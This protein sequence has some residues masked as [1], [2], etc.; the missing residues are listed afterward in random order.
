M[1]ALPS[2]ND[3]RTDSFSHK[4]ARTKYFVSGD[5]DGTSSTKRR[6][7]A[8]TSQQKVQDF[9]PQGGKF[10]THADV[11]VRTSS[12]EENGMGVSDVSDSDTSSSSE[13]RTT[14][15]DNGLLTSSTKQTD[16]MQTGSIVNWNAGAKSKIRTTLG[17]NGGSGPKPPLSEDRTSPSHLKEQDHQTPIA[18]ELEHDQ[19]LEIEPASSNSSSTHH[20]LHLPPDGSEAPNIAASKEL[21][22]ADDLELTANIVSASEN[23]SKCSSLPQLMSPASDT[24]GV[25]AAIREG[26]KPETGLQNSRIATGHPGLRSSWLPLDVYKTIYQFVRKLPSEQERCERTNRQMLYIC[27]QSHTE[28]EASRALP[29]ERRECSS[30]ELRAYLFSFDLDLP[31]Q[32]NVLEQEKLMAAKYNGGEIYQGQEN[33]TEAIFL[34]HL[35]EQKSVDPRRREVIHETETAF[36]KHIV[37]GY[38][39]DHLMCMLL[40]PDERYE[41]GIGSLQHNHPYHT[42]QEY[43]EHM[44]GRCNRLFTDLEDPSNTKM[45]TSQR[46]TKVD[47]DKIMYEYGHPLAPQNRTDEDSDDAILSDTKNNKRDEDI[48]PNNHSSKCSSSPHPGC[49][50]EPDLGGKIHEVEVAYWYDRISREEYNERR[51]KLYT[52]EEAKEYGIEWP[53]RRVFSP[54]G[55]RE[56]EFECPG[57]VLYGGEK[58][59]DL[60]LEFGCDNRDAEGEAAARERFE[61]RIEARFPDIEARQEEYK[62]WEKIKEVEVEFCH[63]RISRDE[64]NERR[65]A[66]YSKGEL[67][68]REIEWPSEH[69]Q[70]PAGRRD[71]IFGTFVRDEPSYKARMEFHWPFPLDYTDT[72]DE[73]QLCELCTP[74]I[75][76]QRI[77]NAKNEE[78]MATRRAIETAE[79]KVKQEKRNAERAAKALEKK[80]LVVE[81][82]KKK[83]KRKKSKVQDVP[84]SAK[85]TKDAMSDEKGCKGPSTR[86]FQALSMLDLAE[87]GERDAESAELARKSIDLPKGRTE[88]GRQ[89][90]PPGDDSEGSKDEGE[91]SEVSELDADSANPGRPPVHK[92]STTLKSEMDPSQPTTVSDLPIYEMQLQSRYFPVVQTGL[93]NKGNNNR[94]ARCLV[95]VGEGHTG[96]NCLELT[97]R[98][99]LGGSS[100]C[101]D[102]MNRF[103]LT[104]HKIERKAEFSIKGRATHRIREDSESE[105]FFRPPVA[106]AA[107]GRRGG[108]DRRSPDRPIRVRMPENYRAR[109]PRQSGPPSESYYYPQRGERERKRSLSPL[110]RHPRENWRDSRRDNYQGRGEG[111][112][113]GDSWQPPLPREPPPTGGG[114]GG[115]REKGQGRGYGDVYRPMPSAANNARRQFRR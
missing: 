29:R 71:D 108:S 24:E 20:E 15:S 67:E 113:R 45:A 111:K 44:L 86:N 47:Y 6:K 28:S 32:L 9:V 98:S 81:K 19:G 109:S 115:G 37:E 16:S 112:G 26:R 30:E 107:R 35:D 49:S 72:S 51:W 38:Q 41:K 43:R 106:G 63:D 25:P 68:D 69:C 88:A 75:E 90:E 96:D 40:T 3:S 78:V 110:P 103:L 77:E 82:K 4:R 84:E 89:Y 54:A 62:R 80:L 92:L 85:V 42:P 5:A 100:F 13:Q 10:N 93:G 61:K 76:Q 105:E 52:A 101:L 50:P 21:E 31:R 64:Y 59:D 94:L 97:P 102:N 12:E 99:T 2:D 56:S 17:G 23:N 66:L 57:P 104:E 55:Y 14:D 91:V 11:L 46:M 27:K 70:S 87:A 58:L 18:R 60:L 114:R 83:K 79:A 8:I 95:C 33:Q 48:H 34:R 65:Y 53:P 39:Y 73:V 7:K 1:S 22:N 74:L 36:T